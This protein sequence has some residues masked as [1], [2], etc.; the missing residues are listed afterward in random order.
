[1]DTTTILIVSNAHI[2]V[3]RKHKQLNATQN[4]QK[5]SVSFGRK[6]FCLFHDGYV[7]EDGE[8]DMNSYDGYDGRVEVTVACRHCEQT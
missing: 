5:R 6:R 8:K 2:S 7:D 3:V 4:V 1:M